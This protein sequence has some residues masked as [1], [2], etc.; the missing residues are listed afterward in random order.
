MRLTVSHRFEAAHR[1]PLY[2]GPCFAL[3]GHGYGLRVTVE[4]KT[5]P[6]TGMGPDF[7]ELKQ[8]VKREVFDAVDHKYLNDL[9]DNPTA[10]NVV[11][12]MWTRLAPHLPGLFEIALDETE[13]CSVAYRG[14]EQGA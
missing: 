11:R 10:E 6:S 14:D 12:W 13:D 7:L 5:D 1:L 9:I 8:V 2:P 4:A 3:H